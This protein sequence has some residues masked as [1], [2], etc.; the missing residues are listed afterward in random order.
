MKI[1]DRILNYEI[2]KQ[3]SKPTPERTERGDQGQCADPQKPCPDTA[4][5]DHDVI[6]DLSPASKSARMIREILTSEPEL[7]E[8]KVKALTEQ[9]A[10]GKYN[11]DF[12]A[13][14]DKL[15]DAFLDDIF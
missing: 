9:I 4:P 15:V 5:V 3:L 11:M 6:V 1:D 8:E 10:S 2:G 13:I 14:A 7:R 12:E